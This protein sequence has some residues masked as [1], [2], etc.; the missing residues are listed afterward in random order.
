MISRRYT[1]SWCHTL[2]G[3]AIPGYKVWCNECGHRADVARLDCDCPKCEREL[4]PE[5]CGYVEQGK[6]SAG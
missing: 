5:E 1:C 4:T 2:S 6:D 3:A